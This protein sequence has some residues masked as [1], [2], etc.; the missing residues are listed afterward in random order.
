M[1]PFFL[2]FFLNCLVTSAQNLGVEEKLKKLS[3]VI[4]GKLPSQGEY[5][6]VSEK[7]KSVMP[8]IVLKDKLNEYLKS[9]E[10]AL[11]FSNKVSDMF[12]M[13]QAPFNYNFKM[14]YT[15]YPDVPM[16][17]ASEN[18]KYPYSAFHLLI[19]EILETNSPWSD[20]LNRKNY[21]IFHRKPGFDIGQQQ[22]LFYS[23]LNPKLVDSNS[24][25][26]E[27]FTATNM[28][29]SFSDDSNSYSGV[30]IS[31]PENDKR[32]AG[33]LTTPSFMMR[34]STTA[35]NSNRRRAAA[36]FRTF[37]CKDMVASIPVPSKDGVDENKKLALAGEG[38]Y[39][40]SDIVDHIKMVQIHGQNV[41]CQFCHK[42][43]DPLGDL[44]NFSPARLNAAAS[45]GGLNYYNEEG[46]FVKKPVDG[47]GN[48]GA[49]ITNER[50]Y[51][52]CQVKH[53]WTWIHGENSLITP[54]QEIELVSTFKAMN[55]KP[56]DFI[57]YL[58]LKDEFY[59]P[60]KYTEAQLSAISAFKT[61]K[62]CQSCHNQQNENFEIQDL[63]WYQLVGNKQ[64]ID[65]A[66]WIKELKKVFQKGSMPPEEAQKDF[67][68]GELGRLK[69]WL[70]QGAPDFE[71]N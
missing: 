37:L 45:F 39:S 1:K 38:Q 57:R 66:V 62:K 51:F 28:D 18:Y 58:V 43:L 53:F 26:L 8:E 9:K 56:Q 35:V 42:Q 3:I 50:D 19:R 29:T 5:R 30:R 47:I 36:V 60:K 59:A 31:F 68:D 52:S 13:D 46:V 10:F 71:G 7:S 25:L 67:T 44:F 6:D 32:V 23:A 21:F 49:V 4:R 55:Q 41:D 70:S 69:N 65:R 17:I 33:V 40:E 63:D 48:L 61:L 34:Y 54:A 27:D 16:S 22:L 12:R 64:S 15:Q 11:K 24:V 14:D 2:I 20:I